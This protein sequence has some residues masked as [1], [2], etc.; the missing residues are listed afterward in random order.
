M[1]GGKFFVGLVSLLVVDAIS[2]R[3]AVSAPLDDLIAGARK[4]GTLDFHGPSTVT[5]QG[6]QAL[7]EALNKR[8]G[9]SVRLNFHP[10][11][12]MTGDVAKMVSMAAAGVPPEWDL[13]VVHD[14]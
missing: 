11:L 1:K 10:T 8:Y 9:L 12:G 7:I 13:T 2:L 14:A 4:E 5:P 3:G 6:A